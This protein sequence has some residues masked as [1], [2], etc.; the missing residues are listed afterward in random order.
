MYVCMYVCMYVYLAGEAAVLEVELVGVDV[1]DAQLLLQLP[2]KVGEA[3]RQDPHL[4]PRSR[5]MAR[6]YIYIDIITL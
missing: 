4:P 5:L 6:I 2:R 3:A 1:V